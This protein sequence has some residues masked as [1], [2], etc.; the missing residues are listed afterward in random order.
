MKRI[1]SFLP[2]FS[3]F[4]SFVPRTDDARLFARYRAETAGGRTTECVKTSKPYVSPRTRMTCNARN[5]VN[6]LAAKAST[7]R[8]DVGT[9]EVPTKR[10]AS[11]RA[12]NAWAP[13]PTAT[14]TTPKLSLNYA[15]FHWH[16]KRNWYARSVRFTQERFAT[17][18][19]RSPN[20]N[21]FS[22]PQPT[23]PLAVL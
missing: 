12:E 19:R 20:D 9:A 8:H 17:A 3:F 2:F 23:E 18:R 1:R 13:R 7:P 14:E 15:C 4:F 6:Q 16:R 10:R 5:K 22:A 21:S 11:D